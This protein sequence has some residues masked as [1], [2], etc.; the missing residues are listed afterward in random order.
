MDKGPRLAVPHVPYK[1]DTHHHFLPQVYRAA[2]EEAGGDP[3]GWPTPDWSPEAS[4]Q[5]MASN[6][7]RKA[8][9]SLTAPGASI[10]PDTKSAR[11]LARQVNEYAASLRQQHPDSFADGVT[12]FTSYGDGNS[13]LGH[14][15]FTPIWEELDARKAVVFVHPTH[16]V[17]TTWTNPILPQPAIDYPHETT[18]TAVDL[19]IANV[20]QNF[21]NCRK[22]LSHAGGSLPYLISRIATTSRA[23]ES[24][25]LIYGKTTG[26]I[27]DDFRSFYYDLALSSS[28]AVLNMVLDLVPHNHVTYGSD[29]PYADS[30]KIAGFREDL[31]AFHM[32][33]KL[34][35]MIYYA[36]AEDILQ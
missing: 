36:N 30:D 32:T 31:D 4:L 14:S 16:P 15:L 9:L 24:T 29:F 6:G 33:H 35:E 28:P 25:K 20:T 7:I 21:P 5:S 8:I 26:D 19:I 18:R 34:R 1:I 17:N 23:T 11:I 10:A 22:I 2:L 27:M 13:Y 3:S 12:L